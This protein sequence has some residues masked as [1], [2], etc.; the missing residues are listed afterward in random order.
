MKKKE[1]W[2]FLTLMQHLKG[3]RQKIVSYKKSLRI[4]AFLFLFLAKV[5]HSKN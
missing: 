1:N 5:S 4:M 3:E 2:Y